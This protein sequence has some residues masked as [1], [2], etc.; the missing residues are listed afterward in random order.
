M[1]NYIFYNVTQ[2]VYKS[3][4]SNLSLDKIKSTDAFTFRVLVT[5]SNDLSPW[6]KSLAIVA[7]HKVKIHT[8]YK[9]HFYKER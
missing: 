5:K 3:G 8:F 2:Q 7:S 9:Q 4:P 1:F 6:R